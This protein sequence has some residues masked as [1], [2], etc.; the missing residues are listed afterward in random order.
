MHTRTGLLLGSVWHTDTNSASLLVFCR[1][2]C[3]LKA[4]WCASR[5]HS[6]YG[7]GL[8]AE[9]YK[10]TTH[11]LFLATNAP[12]H[13]LCKSNNIAER[14]SPNVLVCLWSKCSNSN[15]NAHTVACAK[16]PCA[17]CLLLKDT[18][19]SNTYTR[20]AMSD[21]ITLVEIQSV[22]ISF[23]IDCLDQPQ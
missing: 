18:A 3:D 1:N 12:C 13:I 2:N 8:W 7:P 17:C 10:Q 11:S 21:S 22:H 20:R 4:C 16:S 9:N 23:F 6:V 19:G 14:P 15:C 5:Q